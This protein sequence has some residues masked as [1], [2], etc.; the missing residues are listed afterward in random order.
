MEVAAGRMAQP[1]RSWGGGSDLD[2]LLASDALPDHLWLADS[3]SAKAAWP[4]LE[5][6]R[7]RAH[8]A[9]YVCEVAEIQ[10]LDV[11]PYAHVQQ[12]LL[13]APVHSE[14]R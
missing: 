1:S 7:A 9:G 10:E 4:R 13:E 12:C 8:S 3:G 5:D 14:H 2:Q 6:L 11:A